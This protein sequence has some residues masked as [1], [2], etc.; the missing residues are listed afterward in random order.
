MQAPRKACRPLSFEH[1]FCT[2]SA[3]GAK[4]R[5]WEK[6][7]KRHPHVH[8]HHHLQGSGAEGADRD[9]WRREEG[10]CQMEK[11][12]SRSILIIYGAVIGRQQGGV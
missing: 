2:V 11:A 4:A 1:A 8:L 6:D 3:T 10:P 12:G 9:P 7:L 5:S